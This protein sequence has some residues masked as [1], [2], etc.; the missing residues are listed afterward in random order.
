MVLWAQLR[1]ADRDASD[2]TVEA[3]AQIVA[4]VR[5][6][7]PKVKVIVR[8]DSGFAREAIMGWCEAQEEVYYCIGPLLTLFKS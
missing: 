3:L 8:A 7:L 1:T 6:R 4:A 5:K 2:G